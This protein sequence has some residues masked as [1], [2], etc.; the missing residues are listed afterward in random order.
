MKS[1]LEI[2]NDEMFFSVPINGRIEIDL[3]CQYKTIENPE[4]DQYG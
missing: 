4:Y 2:T 1:I 3:T